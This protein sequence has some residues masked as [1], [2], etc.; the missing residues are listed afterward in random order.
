[1][2]CFNYCSCGC[3]TFQPLAAAV[4]LEALLLNH[5]LIHRLILSLV[6]GVIQYTELHAADMIIKRV[7]EK[8]TRFTE[9]G[10]VFLNLTII[11]V[12]QRSAW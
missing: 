7:F 10:L 2:F 3:S 5:F 12:I 9:F 4:E 8:V 6:R 11:L 1:M